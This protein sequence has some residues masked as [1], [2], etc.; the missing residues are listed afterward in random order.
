MDHTLQA[1]DISLALR[2][3][4][5]ASEKYRVLSKEFDFF[6]SLPDEADCPSDAGH[7]WSPQ[8]L[9][10][11]R[12]VREA[13]LLYPLVDIVAAPARRGSSPVVSI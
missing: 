7:D 9:P 2:R 6:W 1:R 5:S 11:W 12:S 10:Q 4:S 3:S 8:E 13:K